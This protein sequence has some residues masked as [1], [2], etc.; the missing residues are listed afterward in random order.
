MSTYN[1]S[2][3]N[4][5]DK[6]LKTL[7]INDQ[8]WYFKISISTTFLQQDKNIFLNWFKKTIECFRNNSNSF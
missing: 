7:K 1:I 2:C 4:V 8:F 6:Y 5:L 3:L